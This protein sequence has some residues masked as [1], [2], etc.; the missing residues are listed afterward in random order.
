MNG[1]IA[2]LLDLLC[3]ETPLVY[4]LIEA[5]GVIIPIST[6]SGS[7]TEAPAYESGTLLNVMAPGIASD[8][9]SHRQA[10]RHE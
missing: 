9:S 10:V 6:I 1:F 8:S 7:K 2:Y 3:T 5:N 4:R